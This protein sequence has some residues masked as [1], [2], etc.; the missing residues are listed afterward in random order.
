[1]NKGQRV[2]STEQYYQQVIGEKFAF[3]QRLIT[4]ELRQYGILSL[5]TT[6]RQLSVDVINKYLEIKL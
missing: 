4:Q 6:P 5:L 3:E 2:L 1:V